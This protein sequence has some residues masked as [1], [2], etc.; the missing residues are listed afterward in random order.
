MKPTIFPVL[1]YADA[2]AAIDWLIQAFGFQR[3]SEHEGPDG[4]VAHAELKFGPGTVGISS[5]TPP[6]ADNPWSHVREGM[7]VYV[8]DP[9]RH[10]DRARRAGAEIVVPLADQPYGAREYSARDT[11]GNLWA[12]GTY[13]MGRGEGSPTLFPELHYDDPKRALGFLVDA[14][15]FTKTLEVPSPAGGVLHAEMTL[16]DSVLFVG[17]FPQEGEWKALRQLVCAYVEDVDQHHRRATAGGAV[18]KPPQ[19]TPFGARQYATKDPEGFTWLFGT[20]R[21]T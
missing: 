11:E 4:T 9:D 14:F 20:Y 7:Y 3:V 1:R 12:F 2:R 10:H 19:D 17:T 18:A 16:G 6:V 8:D 15:G 13:E 21:P 5:A